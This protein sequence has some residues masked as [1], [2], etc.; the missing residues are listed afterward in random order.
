[1]EKVCL[2]PAQHPYQA[3]LA[4]QNQ[5]QACA[6]PAGE[7]EVSKGLAMQLLSAADQQHDLGARL[8]GNGE[9]PEAKLQHRV[10]VDGQVGS[11]GDLGHQP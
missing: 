5:P 9:H 6:G 8:I 10:V 7:L 11:A 3:R 2:L 4:R 1:M